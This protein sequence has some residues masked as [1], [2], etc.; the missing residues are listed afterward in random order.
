VTVVGELMMGSENTGVQDSNLG[1]KLYIFTLA[2]IALMTLDVINP[3]RSI[4]L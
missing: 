1:G 2:N 3:G 4:T